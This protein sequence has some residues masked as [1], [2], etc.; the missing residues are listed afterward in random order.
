[1]NYLSLFLACFIIPV[2]SLA[3]D[4]TNGGVPL[5]QYRHTDYYLVEKRQPARFFRHQVE[6][7]LGRVST[8]EYLDGNKGS[9][10]PS[11]DYGYG[12][13]TGTI[14]GTYRYF[15]SPKFA[16]GVAAA[17]EQDE[18]SWTRGSVGSSGYYTITTG[19]GTYRRRVFT[20]APEV[21]LT[22]TQTTYVSVCGYI[23]FGVS[24]QNEI[25]T[26]SDEFYNSHYHNGVNDLGNIL[27][28]DNSRTHLNFQVTP[29][30]LSVGLEKW[31]LLGELGFG[32]KGIVRLGAYTRF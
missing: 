10:L 4:T 14:S 32:Y 2:L 3:Q 24:Y 30:S 23:G 1:M 20:I 5:K 12:T 29:L 8:D 7:G 11:D 9:G 15:F 26:Y 21:L 17:F 31:R 16:L 13:S 27:E 25:N 22:Y 19:A 6:V 18:G 28:F